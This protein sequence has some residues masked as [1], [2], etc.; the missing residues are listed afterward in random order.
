MKPLEAIRKLCVACAG[1]KY[2]VRECGGDW[3]VG[4]QGDS[5]NQ[6]YFFNYRNGMGSGRASVK[7][8]ARFC[9][10]CMGGDRE[11]VDECESNDCPLH[12]YRLGRN[13]K[14]AGV[15]GRPPNAPRCVRSGK[16]L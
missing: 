13:P 7:L 9:L 5:N 10:E 6:C 2:A 11:L 8:I 3:C 14:R 4:G 12:E 1:S 16:W 15:G